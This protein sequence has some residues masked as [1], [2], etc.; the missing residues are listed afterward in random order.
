MVVEPVDTADFYWS[1]SCG[2][3]DRDALKFGELFR[4][5][6]A[7]TMPSQAAKA[8]GVETG[9]ARPTCARI[10]SRHSPDHKRSNGGESHSGAKI[11]SPK[12][13]SEF[14]SRPSQIAALM[15][16]AVPRLRAFGATLGMTTWRV[17]L[18][19]GSV[20][21]G[22]RRGGRLARPCSGRRRASRGLRRR[23]GGRR[24]RCRRA[25]R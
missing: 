7:M 18:A 6:A 10:W 13:A 21:R 3:C 24:E 14:E 11:C 16:L 4:C 17:T 2:N 20:R 1:R 9:R 25:E 8:E 22:T 12:R 5:A 19:V 23:S 15:V